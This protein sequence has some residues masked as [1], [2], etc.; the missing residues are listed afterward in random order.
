MECFLSGECAE[1]S[2]TITITD[3][4]LGK[5]M[6]YDL[7][8]ELRRLLS[9]VLLVRSWMP[10]PAVLE[11]GEEVLTFFDQSYHIEAFIP[12]SVTSNLHFYATWNS[13]GIQGVD[14]TGDFWINQHLAGLQDWNDQLDVLCG[15]DRGLW[16]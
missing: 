9:G 2:W 16:E 13:G 7:R 8:V 6:T 14:A 11:G 3:S 12:Q 4:L 10:E 1:L 15:E 5:S